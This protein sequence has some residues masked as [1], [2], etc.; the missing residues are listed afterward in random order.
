M[1]QSGLA[2]VA[3]RARERDDSRMCRR[4]DSLYWMS[5]LSMVV[6]C[7]AGNEEQSEPAVAVTQSD[8]VAP[9][10]EGLDHSQKPPVEQV[11]QV[12]ASVDVTRGMVWVPAGEAR[13]GSQE[14]APDAPMR[15]VRL[16]GFYID[17]AE[18]TN[19][20]F[21][22]FTK[23]TGYVTD[24]ERRPT[25][26]EIPGVPEEL[27]VA[28][29]LVFTPPPDAVDLREFWSWWSYVPGANWRQPTGPGSSTLGREDHP[30]IHVS[31]RDATAYA[32]WARKR[33]PTEAEWEFAARGG[34]AEQRYA[35]GSEQKVKGRWPTNIWQ[36]EFPSNNTEEDGF[37]TTSPVRAFD[38]NRLGIYGMSGNVWEWCQ[39]WYHP[40]GYGD[41][42]VVAVDPVG[43]NTSYDPDEPGAQ[44]R[45]MRGG[46]Y[47]CSDVYCL[48]YLPGTRMKSTPDTSL[49]HTGFRCVVNAEPPQSAP[50]E[51]GK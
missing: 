42:S 21:E 50:A 25:T 8:L 38:P 35:W 4:L 10:G 13:L 33:L 19:R 49:C 44:K 27:L 36:G 51:A 37:L 28:G 46:S 32:K 40:N 6:S 20:D 18:V 24:A 15:T 3:V 12:A 48:G 30:V 23:A 1:L 17:A 7:S 39:D 11:L 41:T 22:A 16:T 45:V 31:W 5:L 47:L 2:E 14:S 34:L 29:S 43:P 26:E 9:G